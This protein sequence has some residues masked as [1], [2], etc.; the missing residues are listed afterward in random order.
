MSPSLQLPPRFARVVVVVWIV[1]NAGM[2]IRGLVPAPRPWSASL[3]WSMFLTPSAVEARTV[4]E[5]LDS[6]GRWLEIPLDR[7]FHFTRGWT[8]RRELFIAL[9]LWHRRTRVAAAVALVGLHA[10]MALTMRVSWLFHG[11]ML[12]HLG[13]FLGGPWRRSRV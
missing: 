7:Y 8:D 13:L 6:S 4:A 3:P 1:A 2:V 10:G 11:L 5:G 12:A 9:G